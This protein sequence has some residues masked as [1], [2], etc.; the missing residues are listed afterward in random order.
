MIE[1]LVIASLV[2]SLA[3]LVAIVYVALKMRG[4]AQGGVDRGLLD[5]IDA[6]VSRVKADIREDSIANRAAEAQAATALRAELSS[7]ATAAR[8]EVSEALSTVRQEIVNQF[9]TLTANQRDSLA[10]VADQVSKLAIG[11]EERLKALQVAVESKLAEIRKDAVDSASGVRKDLT[12]GMQGASNNLKERLGEVVTAIQTAG[13]GQQQQNEAMRLSV[14]KGLEAVRADNEKKLEQM[15][16]TVD[17]KLQGTLNARLGESFK[18]VTDQLERVF[19]SVGEMRNLAADVGGLKKVLSNIKTRGTWGEVALGALLEQVLAPSQYAANVETVPLSGRRVEYAI[20]LPANDDG[21][22][23]WLPIDAKFPTEDYERLVAASELG[24]AEAIAEAAKGIEARIIAAARDIHTKYISPPHTTDFALLFLPSEGLY[25][26]VLRRPGL[27]ERL[28]REYRVTV[29]G[30]TTLAAILNALGMGFRTLAIQ[31]R[32]SE[33]WEV[34]GAVKTEFQNYG[35][36]MESVK[37]SLQAASNNV[38]KVSVR[39]RAIDRK[40]RGVSAMPVP[41]AG[42]M[43]QLTIG[44]GDDDDGEQTE[45]DDGER[46]DG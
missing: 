43:L 5:A 4:G 12:E 25:A 28:Q 41:D 19:T 6:S 11:N 9:T 1:A 29:A 36:V 32:S 17:E 37:R 31:K 46:A 13:T 23:L 24:D 3:T 16:V 10:S 21:K 45:S 20:S 40:L 30:P 8:S 22:P 42:Q 38:D 27:L 26:E 18:Q 2:T 35:K 39:H 44:D 14:E 7:G 34:L 15:R 33:V